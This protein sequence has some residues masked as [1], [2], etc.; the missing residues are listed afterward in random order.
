[1]LVDVSIDQ[2]HPCEPSHRIGIAQ[3]AIHDRCNDLL[4]ELHVQFAALL[5]AIYYRL[6]GF[7]GLLIDRLGGRHLLLNRYLDLI[8]WTFAPGIGCHF[9]GFAQIRHARD[10]ARLFVRSRGLFAA[11]RVYE[12]MRAVVP[13]LFDLIGMVDIEA[14]EEERR[15]GPGAV[16][17]R[18]EHADLQIACRNLAQIR[19]H[20]A[21]PGMC[22]YAPWATLWI[23]RVMR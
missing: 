17:L 22:A 3:H 23:G 8:G 18:H 12:Y 10:G 20:K 6:G 2:L 1:M 15:F 13:E 21:L 7:Y 19:G 5:Q 4:S 14:L 16:E 11:I 9:G